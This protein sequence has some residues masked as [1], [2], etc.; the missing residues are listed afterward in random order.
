MSYYFFF[1]IFLRAGCPLPLISK[2]AKKQHRVKKSAATC[3]DDGTRR[4]CYL[5]EV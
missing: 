5:V 3:A 4:D 1:I 2:P